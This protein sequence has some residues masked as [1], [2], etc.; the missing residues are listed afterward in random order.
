MTEDILTE[1]PDD[2]IDDELKRE[3][4]LDTMLGEWLASKERTVDALLQKADQLID[5][6][7]VDPVK[8]KREQLTTVHRLLSSLSS[9]LDARTKEIADMLDRL[10]W[11]IEEL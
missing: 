2:I 9:V 5:E 3:W 4:L 1:E 11:A 8:Y 6:P 7:L 10:D